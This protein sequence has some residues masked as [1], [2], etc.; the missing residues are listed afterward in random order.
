MYYGRSRK[1]LLSLEQITES[2]RLAIN[3]LLGSYRATCST[4][5]NTRLKCREEQIHQVIVLRLFVLRLIT[6]VEKL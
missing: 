2:K 3:A 6:G 4:R 1:I 5:K